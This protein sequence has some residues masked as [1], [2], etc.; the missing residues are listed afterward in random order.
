MIMGLTVDLA[1]LVMCSKTIL[2][3]VSSFVLAPTNLESHPDGI[4]ASGFQ[5]IGVD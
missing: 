5:E 2:I 4:P 1:K 3:V